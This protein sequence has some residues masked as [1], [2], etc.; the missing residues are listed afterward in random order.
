MSDEIRKQINK[1]RDIS[2]PEKRFVVEGHNKFQLFLCDI[3][4]AE[5]KFGVEQADE[6]F[7]QPY[8]GLFQLKTMEKFRGQGLMTYL[9]EQIF[10]YVKNT[11]NISHILLN[12]YKSNTSAL[13]LYLNCGFEVYKN[14]DDVEDEE[15]YFTLIKNL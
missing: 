14:F 12:V 8:V 13:N 11:L 10:G 15:P 6:L 2:L 3:L 1:L 9:L 7:N 4:A 5:S